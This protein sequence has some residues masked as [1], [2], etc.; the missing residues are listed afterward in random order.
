M[1]AEIKNMIHEILQKKLQET[2]GLPEISTE[3]K[4]KAKAKPKITQFD[5]KGDSRDPRANPETWP[6]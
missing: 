1:K 5:E 4:H 3:A 2:K 6:C